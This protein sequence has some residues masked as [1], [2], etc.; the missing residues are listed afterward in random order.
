MP[1]TPDAEDTIAYPAPC[2][3]PGGCGAAADQPCEGYC[4]VDW[5]DDGH[6]EHSGVLDGFGQVHSDADPGL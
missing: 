4:L 5:S 2:D 1:V 6:P 3:L